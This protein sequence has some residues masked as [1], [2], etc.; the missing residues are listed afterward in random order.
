MP[1]F[2]SKISTGSEAFRTNRAEMLALVERLGEINSRSRRESEKRKAH[3][4]THGQLT[5]HER[6]TRLLDPGMPFLE[7]GNVAGYLLDNKDPDR[8]IPGG[9]VIAGIGFVAGVRVAIV[10]DDSGINAGAMTAAGG[11]RLRRCQEIALQKKLPFVHLV[12][13]AGADLM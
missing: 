12:E 1:R 11:Y 4:D 10:V 3:F 2:V 7:I 5:P 9:N 8:S 6:L 13:C